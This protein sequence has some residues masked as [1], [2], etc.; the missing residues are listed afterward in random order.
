MKGTML[1]R[2][3]DLFRNKSYRRLWT[4]NF[5]TA[6][7]RWMQMTALPWMVL[8]MTNSPL[9]TALVGFCFMAPTFALGWFGGI[10]AD[11]V[12][13]KHLLIITQTTGLVATA[14]LAFMFFSDQIQFWHAY[15]TI[16]VVGSAWSLDNPSRKSL[17]FE[18][19]GKERV[20]NGAALDSIALHG[21]KVFGPAVA[22]GLLFEFGIT[23]TYIVITALY[24]VPIAIT[25]TTKVKTITKSAPKRQSVFQ[26]LALAIKY[27]SNEKMILGIFMITLLMNLLIYPFRQLVP[28]IARDILQVGPDLLGILLAAEGLGALLGAV[29]VMRSKR[30]TQHGK[31]FF[32]GS[33][34]TLFSV[35]GFSLVLFYP[36]SV[37][38][39]FLCGLGTAG[40]STM[41]YTVVML[42]SKEEYRGRAMGIISFAIGI[43][44]L[45]TLFIGITADNLGAAT[46]ITI[47]ILISLMLALAIFFGFPS[48]RKKM[49]ASTPMA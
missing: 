44:P 11:V 8:E 6:V 22:G 21:S 17:L 29:F 18:F 20:T 12:N 24:L 39:L 7:T 26:D 9:L 10:L 45:G 3:L 40:F 16:L 23:V 31:I 4:I 14:G 49:M 25:L 1:I 38:A 48:L 30:I 13:R 42:F 32:W 41:Q 46:S 5:F 2:G 27:V 19:L 47:N 37:A 35:L 43:G 33:A 36:F 15:V 28:V 34:L